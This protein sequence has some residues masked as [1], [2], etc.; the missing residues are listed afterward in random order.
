MTMS[1]AFDAGKLYLCV[2]ERRPGFLGHVF[3][4]SAEEAGAFYAQ[5]LPNWITLPHPIAVE[6]VLRLGFGG[7]ELTEAVG[8]YYLMEDTRWVPAQTE[9]KASVT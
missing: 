5:R 4:D 7:A 6:R 8:T 2:E 1:E 3:A 9:Q